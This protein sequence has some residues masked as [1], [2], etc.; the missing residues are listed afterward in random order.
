MTRRDARG[1]PV[2][3]GSALALDASERALWRMMSFYGT[4]LADL[5][6]AIAAD[7]VETGLPRASRRVIAAS[8][9][10]GAGGSGHG[11]GAGRI[12]SHARATCSTPRSS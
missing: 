9:L 1:N 3:T 11:G 10:Q 12:A 6:A 4:P 7:P 2:S 5:D 8:A